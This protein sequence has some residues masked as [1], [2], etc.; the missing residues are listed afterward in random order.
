MHGEHSAYHWRI[1][2]NG[3]LAVSTQDPAASL[4]SVACTNYQLLEII[5]CMWH[6]RFG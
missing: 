3:T 4:L 5:S 2:W 1:G 6:A